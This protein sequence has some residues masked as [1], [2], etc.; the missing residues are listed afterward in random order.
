[1]TW[2]DPESLDHGQ[3]DLGHVFGMIK[4]AAR[5]A[6]SPLVTDPRLG[7]NM[8][9]PRLEGAR[10]DDLDSDAAPEFLKILNQAD[11]IKKGGTWLKVHEQV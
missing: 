1:M 9:V 11:A 5:P 2:T 3:S 10:R 7:A 8:V 6:L 4:E